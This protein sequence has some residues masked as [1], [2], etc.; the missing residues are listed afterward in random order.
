MT[1]L[2]L[3][4]SYKVIADE[5]NVQRHR[6]QP[7]LE[8]GPAQVPCARPEVLQTCIWTPFSLR[9]DVAPPHVCVPDSVVQ[10]HFTARL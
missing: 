1:S 6:A 8:V 7:N 9:E 10:M 4:P 2:M 3:R 5:I